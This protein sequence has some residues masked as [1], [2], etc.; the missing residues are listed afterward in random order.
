MNLVDA[1]KTGL[2]IRRPH[3]GWVTHPEG[4]GT[5]SYIM[6]GTFM[7]PDYFLSHARIDKEDILAIDWE[8]KEEKKKRNLPEWF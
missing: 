8:V 2:P 5:V 4:F 3:K 7:A 6:S 1:I